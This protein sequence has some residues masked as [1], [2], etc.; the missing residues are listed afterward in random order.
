M[1]P[2]LSRYQSIHH[3]HVQSVRVTGA[4]CP[5]ERRGMAAGYVSSSAKHI[6]QVASHIRQ[7]YWCGL[8]RRA[9]RHSRW[10]CH[11]SAKHI[12]QV[13]S[14][15]ARVTGA[16]CPVE[17]RDIASGYVTIAPSILGRSRHIMPELLV[18]VVPSS[19]AT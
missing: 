5:V 11:S 2:R 17:R 8:S 4:G 10:V 19:A 7:S 9:P 1:V 16:G 13:A 6:G 14:H 12:G 3:L 18:R 15:N